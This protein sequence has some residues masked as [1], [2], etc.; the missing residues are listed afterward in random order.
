MEKSYI[1]KELKKIL[2]SENLKT[3]FIH[4]YVYSFDGSL[5]FQSL[6]VC[7]VFPETEQQ[8]QKIV[9]LAAKLKIPITPRGA[10]TGVTGGA[11]PYL[12]SILIS[13]EKMNKIKEINVSGRYAKV[14]AGVI[15]KTLQEAV[16]KYGLMYPP[17]PASAK[18]STIGGNIANN[19]GGLRGLK[20]G[21]TGD[22]V[23][24]LKVV[25]PDG[26]LIHCGAKT[27][28]NT[29]G[30]NFKSLFIG[31]EGTLGF[32]TKATL[33]LLPLYRYL[34]TFRFSFSNFN[35]AGKVLNDILKS[36]LNLSMLE[37]MDPVTTKAVKN[38]K[39][40]ITSNR[41]VTS[42]IF[43]SIDGQCRHC[44]NTEANKLIKLVKNYNCIEILKTETDKEHEELLTPRR[45]IRPAL[46]TLKKYNISQ[47]IAVPLDKVVTTFKKIQKVSKDTGV[48]IAAFGH[49]G[50]GNI[51]VSNLVDSPYDTNLKIAMEK[52]FKIAV[53]AGGTITGEHGIGR[54]KS[55]YMNIQFS[56]TELALM[57]NIKSSFDKN[58]LFNPEKLFTL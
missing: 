27:F 49:A 47:D 16:K 43:V 38:Y 30:Y 40:D 32:I 57:K 3:D 28:K 48:L 8:I 55:E 22:Y 26:N 51:H 58:N 7:V 11:V 1:L 19:A 44:I 36:N 13:T 56:K 5:I 10:G 31:S 33:K 29:A 6:P 9:K 41:K 35:E 20:Y 46:L 2:T 15:T 52:I 42:F 50:D 54:A 39:P 25:L 4:R 17:D 34:C 18:V 23:L 53:K 37:I 45:N 21:V 12:S 14:E 24:E